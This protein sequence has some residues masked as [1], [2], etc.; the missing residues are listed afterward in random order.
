[1]NIKKIVIVL[2]GNGARNALMGHVPISNRGYWMS[3][4]E[5]SNGGCRDESKEKQ[6]FAG[7]AV[8]ILL[9]FPY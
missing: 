7:L 8:G 9:Y 1:M 6:A 5:P 4:H 3:Q 2:S